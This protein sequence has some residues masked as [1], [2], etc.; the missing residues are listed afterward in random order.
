LTDQAKRASR[1]WPWRRLKRDD[2]RL[3]IMHMRD[4]RRDPR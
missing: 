1:W 3:Q 4:T 2:T